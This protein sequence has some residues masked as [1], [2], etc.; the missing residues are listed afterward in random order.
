MEQPVSEL[1]KLNGRI[2]DVC[3][4]NVRDLKK[5]H[6][7]NFPEQCDDFA[8]GSICNKLSTFGYI[9]YYEDKA[10]AE[11]TL[12]WFLVD[13]QTDDLGLYLA[14]F[15]VLEEYRKLGIGTEL[16]K[17]ILDDCDKAR[18]A[19]MICLH[20]NSKN[21]GA[22]K[23]YKNRG[24]SRVGKKLANFYWDTPDSDAFLMKKVN[25]THTDPDP[26]IVE[27]L[28][29]TGCD[30]STIVNSF[31]DDQWEVER[32]VGK[33]IKYRRIQYQVKWVGYDETT[34]EDAENLNCQNL[35]DEFY[36]KKKE[37][38]PKRGPGRVKKQV[39]ILGI[40]KIDSAIEV[41]VDSPDEGII[42][43]SP[44]MAR[45]EYGNEYMAFLEKIVAVEH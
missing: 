34:W 33:R 21:T 5:L 11:A 35:I 7:R 13:R 31:E 6:R 4:K 36:S 24:F 28:K 20:V 43:I 2:L 37:P 38:V 16:L 15:S 30:S 25:P 9:V 26:D 19:T 22:I 40:E 10:V 12:Q 23:F 41:I 3:H 32:I 1:L 45:I 18:P 27:Y 17:F 8:Y 39:K 29:K 42:R 14:T 44:N